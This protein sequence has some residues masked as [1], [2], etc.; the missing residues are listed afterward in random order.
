MQEV[1]VRFQGYRMFSC[2]LPDV[3]RSG[4]SSGAIRYVSGDCP[5]SEDTGYLPVL[6]LMQFDPEIH[7][8]LSGSCQVIVQYRRIPDIYL[9]VT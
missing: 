8:V 3:I 7:L 5:I 4:D 1:L 9:C 2:A 6:Y